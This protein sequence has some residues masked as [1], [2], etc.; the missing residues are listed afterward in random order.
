MIEQ[1]LRDSIHIPRGFDLVS[2][3]ADIDP[4]HIT[5]CETERFELRD[6][7]GYRVRSYSAWMMDDSF[8]GYFEYDADGV[9]L[10]RKTMGFY[11]ATS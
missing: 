4:E 9:L 8:F 1:H 3:E 6:P 10:D 5:S 2:I 11:A 7:E